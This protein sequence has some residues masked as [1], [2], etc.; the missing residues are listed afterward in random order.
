MVGGNFENETELVFVFNVT[1][2]KISKQFTVR[3]G[4]LMV[5]DVLTLA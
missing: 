2:H 1:V 3:I 4:N 5:W